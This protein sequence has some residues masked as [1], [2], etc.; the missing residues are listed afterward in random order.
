M[1]FG[2]HVKESDTFWEQKS[3]CMA[4]VCVTRTVILGNADE[5]VG[6]DQAMK[7]LICLPEEFEFYPVL[8]EESSWALVHGR[9]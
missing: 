6:R 5:V 1:S 7:G 2:Q 8:C 9:L 4:R 3:F